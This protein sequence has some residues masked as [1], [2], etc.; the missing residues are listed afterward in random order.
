MNYHVNFRRLFSEER[1]LKLRQQTAYLRNLTDIVVPEHGFG[2]YFL[3][4]LE[5]RLLGK[6]APETLERLK[7]RLTESGYW[8]ERFAAF[9][10]SLENAERGTFE[11][12][13]VH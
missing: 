1:P 6:A 8:R 4:Y 7:A 9:G 3:A 10:L 5:S 12:H 13:A 2:L 11:S